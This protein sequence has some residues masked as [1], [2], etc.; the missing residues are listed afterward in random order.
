MHPTADVAI[1]RLLGSLGRRVKQLFQPEDASHTTASEKH[2]FGT[3]VPVQ[4]AVVVDM[5]QGPTNAEHNAPAPRPAE[6]N[7]RAVLLPELL[8]EI[9]EV[10]RVELEDQAD[11][12]RRRDAYVQKPQDAGMPWYRS[13]V[14]YLPSARLFLYLLLFC[15]ATFLGRYVDRHFPPWISLSTRPQVP[16]CSLQV[17]KTQVHITDFAAAQPLAP[18]DGKCRTQGPFATGWGP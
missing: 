2:V 16:N 1:S 9:L 12:C 5:G 11:L 3:D 8:L 7:A 4:K 18:N 15:A 17:H 13:V 14:R 10:D 6:L